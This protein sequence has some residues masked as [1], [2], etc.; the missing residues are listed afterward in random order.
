MRPIKIGC[1]CSAWQMASSGYSLPHFLAYITFNYLY[2]KGSLKYIFSA[3]VAFLLHVKWVFALFLRTSRFISQNVTCCKVSPCP[4]YIVF[5]KQYVPTHSSL[6]EDLVQ[7]KEW[8]KPLP[9]ASPCGQYRLLSLSCLRGLSV[10]PFNV[11]SKYRSL[12]GV[13]ALRQSNYRILS[14]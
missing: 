2:L 8:L 3:S 5:I 12:A 10:T 14:L 6:R 13:L 9:K 1:H 7:V 11:P 4:P